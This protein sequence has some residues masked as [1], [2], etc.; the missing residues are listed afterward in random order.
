M[1]VLICCCTYYSITDVTSPRQPSIVNIRHYL[2]MSHTGSTHFHHS[3]SHPLPVT[4]AIPLCCLNTSRPTVLAKVQLVWSHA[5]LATWSDASTLI[6][7]I[8]NVKTLR[9][10]FESLEF[11]AKSRHSWKPIGKQEIMFCCCCVLFTWCFNVSIPSPFQTAWCVWCQDE[12][13]TVYVFTI[14]SWTPESVV[15]IALNVVLTLH[16]YFHFLQGQT[17]TLGHGD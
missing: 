11:C 9:L 13:C 4:C 5:R 17:D 1:T 2:F 8:N 15:I 14:N 6:V 16:F 10:N 3:K 7:I 12:V